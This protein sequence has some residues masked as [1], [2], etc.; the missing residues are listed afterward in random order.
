MAI[1]KFLVDSTALPKQ[2]GTSINS[3]VAVGHPQ[4]LLNGQLQ[5]NGDYKVPVRE[6]GQ[7]T[8]YLL[9][10]NQVTGVKMAPCGIIAHQFGSQ[11]CTVDMMKDPSQRPFN[12]PEF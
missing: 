1:I 12:I 8:I 10:A 4:F 11:P 3:P 2:G 5:T 7:V 6:G 9:E